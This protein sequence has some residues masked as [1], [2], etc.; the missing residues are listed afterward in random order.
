MFCAI[1]SF[2]LK[3]RLEHRHYIYL[4]CK[5]I[6]NA[7]RNYRNRRLIESVIDVIKE[8]RCWRARKAESAT[9]IVAFF[10]FIN[11]RESYTVKRSACLTIQAFL[12]KVWSKSK[13]KHETQRDG[14]VNLVCD[15]MAAAEDISVDSALDIENLDSEFPDTSII[16]HWEKLAS[17]LV[18]KEIRR[19]QEICAVSSLQ[20]FWRRQVIR[21]KERHSL[22]RRKCA[23]WF[24]SLVHE[25]KMIHITRFAAALTIQKHFRIK[26]HH[27]DFIRIIEREE[28]MKKKRNNAA[29]KI[30]LFLQSVWRMR[31]GKTL[32]ALL[33]G[34]QYN[35]NNAIVVI[36]SW[37]RRLKCQ[38]LRNHKATVVRRWKRVAEYKVTNLRRWEILVQKKTQKSESVAAALIQARFRYIKEKESRLKASNKIASILPILLSRKRC[39]KKLLI[40][41][42]NQAACTIQKHIRR[43]R[44]RN[45]IRHEIDAAMRIEK[46]WRSYA[47]R[48]LYKKLCVEK[49]KLSR[50][51]E[52]QEKD[53]LNDQRRL[54]LIQMLFQQTE[55]KAAT[56][57]QSRCRSFLHTLHKEEELRKKQ[58]DEK[59]KKEI[60]EERRQAFKAH[61][62]RKHNIKGIAKR[63]LG[64]TVSFLSDLRTD[65]IVKDAKQT[66][67]QMFNDKSEKQHL[68]KEMIK[69]STLKSRGVSH[70]NET[71]KRFHQ[72]LCD[73]FKG[74]NWFDSKC[75]RVIYSYALWPHEIFQLRG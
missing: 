31:Q 21:K 63:Y 32:H 26:Q 1:K 72:S 45:M 74:H 73:E 9:I 50:A 36:Q 53:N 13:K 43:M 12:R 16:L 7:F 44:V 34:L 52:I 68:V 71:I 19:R 62:D 14:L 60:E 66:I 70:K 46:F 48:R 54:K 20:Q 69:Y 3:K 64:E 65:Q 41:K 22:M 33:K 38:F 67:N 4:K 57:I 2:F 37:W 51:M 49:L 61:H 25:R 8:E 23:K 55:V 47:C 27:H 39:R 24:S 17:E 5:T 56:L 35:Q 40:Q 29:V 28:K 59:R 42:Q 75:E 15:S 58:E 11:E 30:A 6:Q 18:D 10:R